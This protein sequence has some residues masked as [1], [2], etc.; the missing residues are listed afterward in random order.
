MHLYRWGGKLE[1]PPGSRTPSDIT[2]GRLAIGRSGHQGHEIKSNIIYNVW[3]GSWK[4]RTVKRTRR[5][6]SI[7]NYHSTIRPRVWFVVMD[8]RMDK[9]VSLTGMGSLGSA[10]MG[11]FGELGGSGNRETMN[12]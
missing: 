5:W 1:R 12:Y 10:E 8:W 9:G 4:S 3:K 2:G 7:Q 11:G 6:W